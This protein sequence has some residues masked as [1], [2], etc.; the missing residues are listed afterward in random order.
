MTKRIRTFGTG[1]FWGEQLRPSR[2]S[3]K[4][5]KRISRGIF[6]QWISRFFEIVGEIL[7]PKKREEYSDLQKLLLRAGCRARNS[8]EIYYA[9]K[10]LCM[11]LLPGLFSI[12]F[13]YI[14]KLQTIGFP[15]FFLIEALLG[16]AG[17]YSPSLY[18]HVIISHRK[19]QL[20]NSF[21]DMLDLLIVCVEAGI[22]L[23]Q[24]IQ[25]ISEELK[26]AHK[27]LGEEL[28]ILHLELKAGKTRAD[29]LR[30]FAVRVD[31][32]DVRSLVSM[33]IQTE[34]FGT[35]VAKTLKVFSESMKVKR[36]QKAEEIAA[37]IPVKL[38]IPMILFIFP[39][40]FVPILGPAVIQVLRLIKRM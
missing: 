1:K 21:P 9:A 27:A 39:A 10:I 3:N 13:L 5:P 31:L 33:L 36:Y 2:E 35:S 20:F 19:E 22:S 34:K 37:K 16:I 40:M 29:A 12:L 32:D 24:A 23:N 7:K 17:F 14:P 30:N 28:Q 4:K 26:F 6:K 8:A 38:T 15:Q 11:I 18:L 25:Q